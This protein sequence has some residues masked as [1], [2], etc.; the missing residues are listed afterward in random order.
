MRRTTGKP[1]LI[2]NGHTDVVPIG[3][4]SSWTVN[5][6]GG[7]IIDGKIYGR[8]SAD[9]KGGLAA[10]LETLNTIKEDVKIKGRYYLRSGYR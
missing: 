9:M 4:K 1:V 8:G 7:E 5:P 6:F 3:E 2:F 10:M